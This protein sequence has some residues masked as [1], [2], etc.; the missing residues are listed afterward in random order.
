MGSYGNLFL[1]WLMFSA[2]EDVLFSKEPGPI[3]IQ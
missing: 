3:R 1:N 2:Q